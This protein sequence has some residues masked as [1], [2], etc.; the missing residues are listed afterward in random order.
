MADELVGSWAGH[1]RLPWLLRFGRVYGTRRGSYLCCYRFRQPTTPL[2]SWEW[3][4]KTGRVV[5]TL[6]KLGAGDGYTYLTNQV[7]REDV[8]RTGG[9]TLGEY[10]GA[11]NRAG[12]WFGR[13]AEALGVGGLVSETQMGNLFGAGV[14]PDT[15][16]RL[17]QPFV[18]YTD[19]VETRVHARLGSEPDAD[20]RRRET[21]I[22]EEQR[23]P[24]RQSVAGYDCTFAPVKSVSVLWAVADDQTRATIEAAHEAAWQDTIGWLEDD[25]ARTRVG[26]D[27]IRFA[28]VDG[29]VVAAFDHRDTRTGDPQLHT[30]VVISNKVATTSDGAWRAL[31]GVSLHRAAVAASERYNS[32]VEAHLVDRLEVRF[33]ERPGPKRR[34][35]RELQGVPAELIGAFSQRRAAITARYGELLAAYRANHGHEPP[36]N[37]QYRLGQQATLDTRSPKGD[38]TTATSERDQWR[39][40]A[41]AVT[42]ADPARLVAEVTGRARDRAVVSEA[43]L[44]RW[45]GQVL[46]GLEA[47]RATWNRRHIQA[48]TERVTRGAGVGAAQRADLVA[49]VVTRVEGHA[50]SVALTPPVERAPVPQRLALRNGDSV[51]RATA[52]HRWTT[53]RILDAEAALEAAHHQLDGPALPDRDVGRAL[54]TADRA[55]AALGNDQTQAVWRLATSGHRLDVLIGP[56]GAGKTRTVGVL[57]DAWTQAGATTVGLAPSAAAAGVLATEL[58]GVA[59]DNTAKWLHEHHNGGDFGRFAAGQLVLVDEAGMTDTLTLAAITAEAGRTGAKVVLVGD[60]MQL[61][62]VGGGGALRQLAGGGDA[63][64]LLDLWRF[65]QPWEGLAT[66]SLRDGDPSVIDLYHHHGRIHGGSRD[67]MLEAMYQAWRTDRDNGRV[68]LMSAGRGDDVTTLSARARTDLVT[69]G[70]VETGGVVLADGTVAGR[71]D[72]I[73]TRR[74]DRQLAT[75]HGQD[76]VRNGD[77]WRVLDRGD[78]GS[79]VVRNHSHRGTVTLPADYV[80]ADVQL[81]YATTVHRAQGS[82]VDISHALIDAASTRETAYVAMTRG[83]VAN[84]AWV[85][86]DEV[87][88]VEPE[89]PPWPHGDAHHL[90]TTVLAHQGNEPA[91][92][93]VARSEHQTATSTARLLAHYHDVLDQLAPPSE[94][95]LRRAL[96]PTTADTVVTDDA[97]PALD[98]RIRQLVCQD[99]SPIWSLQ[100]AAKQGPM[101][102]S[103][104][105]AAVLHHRLTNRILDTAHKLPKPPPKGD[106]ELVTYAHQLHDT[107]TQNAAIPAGYRSRPPD[108]NLQTSPTLQHE[109][110]L[111]R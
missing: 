47:E 16:E 96:D 86:T 56:A 73:V 80:A 93:E 39:R 104:S 44:E 1:L 25:V 63:A 45:A 105:P 22:A 34:P 33:A 30:H 89:R 72:T 82:T 19:T 46:D 2:A 85:I 52:T 110:G 15:A 35:V 20:D 103:N 57:V 43:D 75:N 70:V 8:D 92:G 24:S 91:A 66:L 64:Q 81:G 111:E 42:G 10:Y 54:V 101:T 23:R 95:L 4:G 108:H 71:G 67:A 12:Q 36:R 97:W 68:A 31:D 94:H 5:M 87:L 51:W 100:R 77:L 50:Q 58:G 109:H 13:G 3:A 11:G 65:Q 38:L 60:P 61:G 21:I 84:H 78:N 27:G 99:A 14:H 9:Q 7:A 37:L 98:H 17:G 32:L 26:R 49:V 55:G 107:L 88:E 40:T 59:C 29:L 102:A 79:L 83:R 48:E 74:N 62:A 53:T 41:R 6:H 76:W 90:L 106:P 18:L 28:D 69:A